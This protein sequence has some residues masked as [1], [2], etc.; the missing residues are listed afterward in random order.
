[1][2][3]I[4]FGQAWVEHPPEFHIVTVATVAKDHAFA[5][6]NVQEPRHGLEP[7]VHLLNG[8][9]Q[10][11]TAVLAFPVN[12][13]QSVRQQDFDAVFPCRPFQT[14]HQARTIAA[15]VGGQNVR[16]NWPFVGPYPVTTA[17]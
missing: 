3:L 6:A 11:P 10:D 12:I 14:A 5:C 17:A 2:P 1:M 7:T 4:F 15:L 9:P 13:P 16:R 8:N